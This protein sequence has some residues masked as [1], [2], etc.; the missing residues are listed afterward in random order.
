MEHLPLLT[1]TALIASAPAF[2]QA[3]CI[4]LK[5]DL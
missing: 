3:Q 5:P 1:A 2:S 4:P